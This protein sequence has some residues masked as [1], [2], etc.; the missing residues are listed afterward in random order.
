M[1]APPLGNQL[2]SYLGLCVGHVGSF[3]LWLQDRTAVVDESCQVR[4]LPPS[5][6]LLA[7]ARPQPFL[8]PA[9]RCAVIGRVGLR[10]YVLRSLPV[11]M[12]IDA[13]NQTKA[14]APQRCLLIGRIFTRSLFAVALT[15]LAGMLQLRF[16][17]LSAVLSTPILPHDLR[18]RSG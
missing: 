7:L 8:S 18:R 14:A 4:P 2:T 5:C 12:V 1:I 16:S 17:E 11:Q 15:W 13:F 6:C 9:Y 10:C 3:S